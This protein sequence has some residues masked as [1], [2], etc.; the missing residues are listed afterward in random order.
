MR[1]I[2][3]GSGK[4]IHSGTE[5][6]FERRLHKGVNAALGSLKHATRMLDTL[7]G[8]H[9]DWYPDHTGLHPDVNLL[10]NEIW[11]WTVLLSWYD[12][13]SVTFATHTA[14]QAIKK[15]YR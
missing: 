1:R 13:K 8:I 9:R 7:A 5:K 3:K 15:G 12:L 6:G 14:T 10:R 4:I 2:A 11:S